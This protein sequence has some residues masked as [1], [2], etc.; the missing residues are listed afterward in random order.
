[1]TNANRLV[2]Q[3]ITM[4][5]YAIFMFVQEWI[6]KG[7]SIGKFITGTKA[8]NETN[9]PLSIID[10]LKRNFTRAV[11]FEAFSFFGQNGLHDK[12]SNTRVVNVKQFEESLRLRNEMEEI[13]Q[14]VA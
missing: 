4:V 1:M 13:G 5:L 9:L 10:L 3:F 12:W 6:F 14:V 11:P 7:R 8:V 2:D